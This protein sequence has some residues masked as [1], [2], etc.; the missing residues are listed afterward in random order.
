MLSLVVAGAA[1]CAGGRPTGERVSQAAPPASRSAVAG[2]TSTQPALGPTR[3]TEVINF[4]VGS[5][6]RLPPSPPVRVEIPA[7]GVSSSLVRLG[8]NPDRTMEVPGDFQVAGWFTGAPQP[9]QLGPA[10]IAGHVDSRTGPAVFYRLRDLRPGDQI[11]VVRADRRVVRFKVDSLASYPK[12]SLPPDA[13][14]GA[15]TTPALRLITCAGSFD[16]SSRSYRDN[17]VVSATR[18]PDGAGAAR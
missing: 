16:R 11:R 15:T 5:W 14:Y 13:V 17:L 18:V 10:V 1:G 12:Q 7:I 3:S 6:R 2:A 8:L 9:G 4:P